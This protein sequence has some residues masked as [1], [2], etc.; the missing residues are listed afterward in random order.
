MKRRSEYVSLPHQNGVAAEFRQN[1]NLGPNGFKN[2]RANKNHFDALF[3][4]LGLHHMHVAGELS[5]VAV[6]QHRRVQ[7]SQRRLR[8][9]VH[10]ASQ[11]NR[12]GTGAVHRPAIDAKFP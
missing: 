2:R 7:Q 9:P 10:F 4:Q 8:R 3:T 6:P 11:Q 1:F 12:A 5:S